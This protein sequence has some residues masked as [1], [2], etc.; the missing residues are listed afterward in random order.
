MT[1]DTALAPAVTQPTAA[2]QGAAPKVRVRIA[3]SGA[4]KVRLNWFDMLLL[5][6]NN[7]VI[8][9]LPR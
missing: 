4:A 1:V 9:W 8:V 2:K 5:A 3:S 6:Y 7:F